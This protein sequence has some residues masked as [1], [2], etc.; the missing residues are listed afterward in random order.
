[1]NGVPTWAMKGETMESYSRQNCIK[2]SK[3]TIVKP[4][5]NFTQEW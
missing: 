3:K 1:M 4:D 2:E 5:Q